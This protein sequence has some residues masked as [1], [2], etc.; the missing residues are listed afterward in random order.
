MIRS[1]IL[2]VF[3]LLPISALAQPFAPGTP[4]PGLDYEVIATPQPTFGQGKIEV[5]EVFSYGCVH[6]Y[7]F[8]PMV[9]AWKKS[10]PAD[11]RWEYVPAV[12]G[13]PAD[14]FARAFFAAQILGVQQQ[15][16]DAVF[17]AIFE[18]QLLKSGTLEAI[19][20]LYSS[21]GVSR[22]KMLATMQSAEV[23]AKLAKAK[24]F[25]LSTDI[26]GTP[27]IVVNG[28]YRVMGNTSGGLGQVFKTVDFLIAEERA[29]ASPVK[30]KSGAVSAQK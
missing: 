14:N 5:A 17:K 10:I 28:K 30:P 4:K 26:S 3:L 25:A 20:D 18:D 15:T 1:F 22:S 23:T 7:H 24:Q 11:V 12:F 19:A 21:I 8:Q 29:L 13:G 2:S 27:T 9:N 16:Q 6:C